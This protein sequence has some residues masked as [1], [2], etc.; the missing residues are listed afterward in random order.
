M[1]AKRTD[2]AP[3]LQAGPLPW[4]EMTKESHPL[5]HD[6]Q[7]SSKRIH[8]GEFTEGEQV[9]LLSHF[10]FRVVQALEPEAGEL[11]AEPAWIVEGDEEIQNPKWL[12]AERERHWLRKVGHQVLDVAIKRDFADTE[13][14][15][16]LWLFRYLDGE[17]LGDTEKRDILTFLNLLSLRV[18]RAADPTPMGN[19]GP[20]PITLTKEAA[21]VLSFLSDRAPVLATLDDIETGVTLSRATA[22]KCVKQLCAANYVNRPHGPKK[23]VA[24]TPTGLAIADKL[25]PNL[26]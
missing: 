2:S 3:K 18:H 1:A 26:D 6:L 20:N 7:E 12:A 23:G 24:A 4:S 16:L 8:R 19:S 22:E 17:P 13:T 9:D 11:F 5:Q 14:V 15:P 21:S 25:S 10:Y